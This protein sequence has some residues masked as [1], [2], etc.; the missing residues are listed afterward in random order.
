MVS[1]GRDEQKW[2]MRYKKAGTR[3]VR[4]FTSDVMG[5]G[6]CDGKERCAG[7]CAS[8]TR[9]TLL[10]RPHCRVGKR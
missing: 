1:P 7:G 9:P 6:V 4:L 10:Q 5:V 2:R 8:L 3:G